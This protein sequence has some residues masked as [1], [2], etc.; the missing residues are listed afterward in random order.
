MDNQSFNPAA[1][2]APS[3]TPGA[4]TNPYQQP[5]ANQSQVPGA[6][7]VNVKTPEQK[8]KTQRLIMLIAVIIASLLAATFL[9]LFVW[10]YVMW[11]EA[12][13]D[14][15][16]QVEKAVAIAVNEKQTEL[17]AEFEEKEKYPLKT[18]AGPSD[19]GSLT[20]EFPKTW[21]VYVPDNANYG[22]N[23]HAFLNPDLVSVVSSGTINALRVSI[24]NELTDNVMA[25]YQEAVED[26]EMTVS[27]YKVNGSN[28][29][30]YSGLLPNTDDLRGYV[31]IFKIRDK[32]VL[33]QTDAEIFKDDFLKI[34]DTV[35][36]NV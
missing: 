33:M 28:A 31:A 11:D 9:G 21:S 25:D 17:E 29:S 16:G 13:T 27:V 2:A 30:L 5:I 23:Y 7:G 18:F 26:G 10:M 12:K 14:V 3:V 24:L 8:A 15:D 20:F 34:L 36:Y 35:R 19:Y 4:S 22:G 32:T 1:N 6:A